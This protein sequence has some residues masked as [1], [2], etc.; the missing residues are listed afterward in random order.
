MLRK[1]FTKIIGLILLFVS[2]LGGLLV[3]VVFIP[4]FSRN[5][6]T[7]A[8]GFVTLLLTFQTLVL[9]LDFGLSILLSR[10]TALTL[11]K[12]NLISNKYWYNAEIIISIF[13]LVILILLVFLKKNNYS[14]FSTIT[15]LQLIF[16]VITLWATV[17]QNFCQ[18]ILL[19]S[20]N[21]A[22]SSLTLVGG[23]ILKAGGA[24]AVIKF[25]SPTIDAYILSQTI[26]S[27]LLLLTT[28]KLSDVYLCLKDEKK[29]INFLV[30]KNFL[31][32]GRTLI[33]YSLSA[34]IILNF[35]K[36][37]VSHNISLV[38]LAPYFLASSL[39]AIPISV[40]SGSVMQ[41]FQ[42]GLTKAIVESSP[43]TKRLL[44]YYVVTLC[45]VTLIP[46]YVLWEYRYFFIGLWLGNSEL[47]NVVAS[48]TYILLPGVAIGGLGYASY[49]ILIAIEDFKFQSVL[50]ISMTIIVVILVIFFSKKQDIESIC[51][52]YSVYHI[53]STML[54]WGRCFYIKKTR[55]YALQMVKSLV[56]TFMVL[57][58]IYI[59]L[60]F[61]VSKA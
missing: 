42:P 40:L 24:A 25:I 33:L 45:F 29:S 1:Q 9:L 50:S 57:A 52:V 49:I 43:Q 6:S 10:Y 53:I 27:I 58:L 32:E 23:N 61:I 12:E 56:S 22:M 54:T 44:S 13:Y 51:L 47:I 36:I 35:D 8:F 14:L 5:M 7:E 55:S 37:I 16:I 2:K 59:I 48:Y 41:F 31:H 39:C 38:A 15:A 30:I 4:V 28:R 34:A 18:T 21:F 3:G 60:N 46:S 26:F 19:A 20:K 17:L 11:T